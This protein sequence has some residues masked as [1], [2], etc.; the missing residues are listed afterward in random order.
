[1]SYKE[2][3]VVFSSSNTIVQKATKNDGTTVV[4]KKPAQN[5]P[6]ALLIESFRKDFQFTKMLHNSYPKYFIDMIELIEQKNGS[7]FLVEEEGTELKSFVAEKKK[8]ELEEFLKVAIDMAKAVS[9]S[10]EKHVLHRD[11][12]LRNFLVGNDKIVKL[13]DFGLAVVVS[14]KSPSVVCNSPIGTYGYMSP[15]QTGRISKN[16]DFRSDIYS[17]GITFYELLTGKLPFVG[18]KMSVVH[19]HITKKIPNVTDVPSAINEI[20]QKM[21]SKNPTD[22]YISAS[23]VVKD[24]EFILK[25]VKK[26]PENF[27]VGKEDLKQFQIP[28]KIYG[29][30]KQVQFLRDIITSKGETNMCLVSGYSGMG[31]S[32][33]MSYMFHSNSFFKKGIN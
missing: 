22:R 29:R 23:G 13:I 21:C 3:G 30:N 7:V 27:V 2:V 4:I 1:M 26:I 16:V 24:L 31:K 11:I 17:L 9:C 15:E 10:H 5:F 8:I 33:R 28:N 19:S 6:D 14:R 25:N 32:V 20:I 12:K 18:D